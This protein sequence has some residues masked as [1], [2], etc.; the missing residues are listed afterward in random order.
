MIA[1]G[2]DHGGFALKKELIAYAEEK[3]IE[4]H[5]YGCYSEE[6]CDYPDMVA[7]P[8]AAVVSGKCSCAILICG[9][10]IGISI[11]A[12]KIKGIRAACCSD[13]YSAKYTRLHNDANVLC[14]GGRVI[15]SGLAKELMDVFLNTSFEGGRHQK[16]IDKISRL[17]E[18]E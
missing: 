8:C 13:Y 5:D 15:G 6:S 3:G 1:F 4:F 11:S 10:G 2:S 9:S 18:K 14:M 16:R 7:K 12:N 17:E